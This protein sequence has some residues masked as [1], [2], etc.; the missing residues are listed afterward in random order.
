MAKVKAQQTFV[1]PDRGPLVSTRFVVAIV[2][3]VAGI[4]WMVYYYTQVRVDPTAVPPPA[5]GSPAF[6]ADLKDWNYAI[7]FGLILLGLLL[8][9]HP[10]TPLGRDR[11]VVVGMLTCF[12][13]GLLWIC[14]FYVLSGDQLPEGADLQRPRPVQ[15]DGRDR[16]HGRRLRLRDALGVRPPGGSPSALPPRPATPG[17]RPLVSASSC[18]AGE[19]ALLMVS[20]P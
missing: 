12:L 4:A 20:S 14:T 17:I 9:A 7:G 13:F 8:C 5:A 19:P 15:P 11:G 16:L 3:V 6:M 2:L 18:D 1:D 10:S